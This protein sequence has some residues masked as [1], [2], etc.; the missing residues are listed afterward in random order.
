VLYRDTDKMGVVY[1]GNFFTFFE[2]GRT[3]LMRS[4]GKPYS[5]MEKEGF[6][7]V[8]SEAYAKYHANVTYDDEM[9]IRTRVADVTNARIRFE[10]EIHDADGALLVTG[11]T[12]HAC[13][14]GRG[15]VSRI[16]TA[17]KEMLS[18]VCGK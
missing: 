11:F 4:L 12:V 1:Y 17:F 15:K 10:Y 7:L 16:P 3:E 6:L 5:A 2:A 18:E 13:M 14:D 9:V 8:V